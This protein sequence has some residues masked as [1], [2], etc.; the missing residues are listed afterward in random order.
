ME[1]TVL[2]TARSDG[3]PTLGCSCRTCE[4]ARSRGVERTRFS[5]HVHNDRTGE[6]LLVDASPDLRQ[7]FQ[8]NEVALPDAVVITHMHY[9]HHAGLAEFDNTVASP[10]VHAPDGSGG[11]PVLPGTDETSVAEEVRRRYGYVG[12]SVADH[13]PFERFETCGFVV[14]LVP[15]EHGPIACHGVVVVDPETGAKLAISGDTDYGISARSREALAD[16]DLLLADAMTPANVQ[17]A[18]DVDARADRGM[19]TGPRHVEDGVAMSYGRHLTD[20]GALALGEELNITRTRFVHTSHYYPPE[21]AFEEPLLSD[22][23]RFVL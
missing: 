15:V 1:V 5:V 7:Q 2:G 22:G 3:L 11:D 20:E 21:T 9:D 13:P 19:P 18:V 12:F 6:T 14:T 10:R 4:T 8:R 23:A 16:A 17:D